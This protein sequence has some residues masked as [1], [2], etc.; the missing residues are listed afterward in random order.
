MRAVLILFGAVGIIVIGAV[1]FAYSGLYDVSA[2]KPHTAPIRW[3][4]ST[5][6]EAA[7]RRRARAVDVPSLSAESLAQAGINDYEAMCVQCH[8]A[9]GR[10]PTALAQG[11]NPQAP[12]LAASAR[13]LS[14]A[15]LFWV[16]KHGVKMTGMPAWGASHDDASLWPVVAFLTRL[17]EL[18]AA[19]YR[20]YRAA[21]AGHGHHDHDGGAGSHDDETHSAEV[22]NHGSAK[23]DEAGGA[24]NQPANQG[25]NDGAAEAA[26]M[27]DTDHDGHDHEH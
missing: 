25:G 18:D 8:G 4:L 20:A 19:A 6:S 2:N 15:E 16:T 13:S 21:A 26:D 1:A 23:L 22:E 9:P 27:A 24:D 17:P 12:D 14:A 7:I 3:L 11:L 10:A 5:T